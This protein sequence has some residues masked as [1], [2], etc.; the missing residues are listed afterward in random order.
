MFD[1]WWTKTLD[2]GKMKKED[3][4]NF[5]SKVKFLTRMSI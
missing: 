1:C 4:V 2:F 5:G 3:Y